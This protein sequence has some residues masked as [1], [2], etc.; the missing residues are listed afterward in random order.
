VVDKPWLT[1]LFHV[2]GK[3]MEFNVSPLEM[4]LSEGQM[5]IWH[6]TKDQV[7]VEMDLAR[8]RASYDAWIIQQT[9]KQT[10]DKCS[11]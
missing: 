7:I 8:H 4:I 11:A 10:F 1:T 3:S 9:F 5:A 2:A 6:D